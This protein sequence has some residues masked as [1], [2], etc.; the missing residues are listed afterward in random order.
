MAGVIALASK[1]LNQTKIRLQIRILTDEKNI[2]SN[3]FLLIL[4]VRFFFK[5]FFSKSDERK[6][7]VLQLILTELFFHPIPLSPLIR[8][9]SY[10]QGHPGGC[11]GTT[12]LPYDTEMN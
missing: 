9:L 7:M 10:T 4:T 1:L 5:L 2:K 6:K 3:K 12:P 11:K 8:T